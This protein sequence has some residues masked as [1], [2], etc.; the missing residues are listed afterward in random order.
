MG[1][2]NR[3]ILH[4]LARQLADPLFM[5][6]V[7]IGVDQRNGDCLDALCFEMPKRGADFLFV[8]RTHLLA[9]RVHPSGNFDGV[10]QRCE[11]LWFG[12]DDPAREPA[13][14]KTA[15]NLH[16]MAIALG[17]NQA[18]TCALALKHS[19]SRNC[20]AVQEQFYIGWS[21]S[22]IGANGINAGQY[23]DRGVR[24]CRRRF[25]PPECPTRLVEQ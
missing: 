21:N 10:F 6:A 16:D 1:E 7:G 14:Y 19:I 25:M 5:R 11:W 12:P 24:R 22:R 15:R 3:H 4:N 13:G 2:R 23:S 17:G 9:R 20:R 8:D 18:D